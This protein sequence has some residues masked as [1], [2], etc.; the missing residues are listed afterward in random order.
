MQFKRRVAEGLRAI[1]E[2]PERFR[3]DPELPEARRFRLQQFPFS[4]IY[5][6]RPEHIWIV[7]VA[8]GSRRPGYWKQRL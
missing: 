8:H 7:A 1:A 6:H 3:P 4:L 5:I 2:N